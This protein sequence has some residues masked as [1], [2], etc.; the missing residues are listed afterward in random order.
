MIDRIL[1]ALIVVSLLAGAS[2]PAPSSTG[3]GTHMMEVGYRF[4]LAG[5]AA[6][7]QNFALCD[8]QL[9]ELGEVLERLRAVRRPA[10]VPRSAD[11]AGQLQGW[12]S[13][14]LPP[15]REAAKAHDLRAFRNAY[16]LAV[17]QCNTC[18]KTAN[19]PFLKV[20]PIPQGTTF[21]DL[22]P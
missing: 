16:T 8:Y 2:S 21:L 20:P 7:S 5:R 22:A 13:Q 11:L 14:T 1:L 4:A 6:E 19:K 18:H 15:L 10:D 3:W 9:D 12:L 17:N